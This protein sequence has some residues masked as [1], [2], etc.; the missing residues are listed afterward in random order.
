MKYFFLLLSVFVA[1]LDVLVITKTQVISFLQFLLFLLCMV[2][3]SLACARI[4][5]TGRK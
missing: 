5:H 4:G 3:F 2:V 1:G